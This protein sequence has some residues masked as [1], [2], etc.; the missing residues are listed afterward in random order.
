MDVLHD[1]REG[2]LAQIFLARLAHGTGWR[3]GPEGFIVGA[4]VVVAGE[5]ESAG[6]PENEH[7]GADPDR[8]PRG[9]GAKQSVRRIAENKRRVEGRKVGAEFVMI[10]LQRGPGGVNDERGEA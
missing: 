2:T 8:Y 6:G 1:Q 9:P 10:A 5:A 3:I 7:G 4:A